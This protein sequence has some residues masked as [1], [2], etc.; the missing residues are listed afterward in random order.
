MKR[1]NILVDFLHFSRGYIVCITSDV[2]AGVSIAAAAVPN[3]RGQAGP[4]LKATENPSFASFLNVV[5]TKRFRYYL[6][7]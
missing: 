4:V 6:Q 7:L 2:R 3:S 5:T 1:F